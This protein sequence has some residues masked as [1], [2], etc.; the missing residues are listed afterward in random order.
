MG[1]YRSMTP[2]LTKIEELVVGTSSG[3]APKLAGG[4]VAPGAG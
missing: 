2:L 4:W 1:E 3:K